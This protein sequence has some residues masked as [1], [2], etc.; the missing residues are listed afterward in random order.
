MPTGQNREPDVSRARQIDRMNAVRG[1]TPVNELNVNTRRTAESTA[2]VANRLGRTSEQLGVAVDHLEAIATDMR[3]TQRSG[4]VTLWLTI[5]TTLCAV[6]T[7]AVA[8]ATVTT[9]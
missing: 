7:L 9:T 5:L 2:D 8:L 6:G 3:A 4:R 1:A